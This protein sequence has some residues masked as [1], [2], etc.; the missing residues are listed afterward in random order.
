MIGEMAT[1]QEANL[2]ATGIT[3]RHSRRC[4][5][6]DAGRCNCER[7]YEAWVYSK[8]DGRRSPRSLP[9]RPRR[10]PGELRPSCAPVSPRRNRT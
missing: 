8:R 5:S 10:S 9:A 6:R 2:M 3:K 7:T 1:D 4:R